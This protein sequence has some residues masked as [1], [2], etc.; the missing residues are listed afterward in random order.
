MFNV[1]NKSC[2]YNSLMCLKKVNFPL[3]TNSICYDVLIYIISA[4]W[5]CFT[6]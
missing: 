1:P 4:A 3:S 6:K 2:K 5:I